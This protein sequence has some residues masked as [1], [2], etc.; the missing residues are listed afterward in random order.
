MKYCFYCGTVHEEW[1]RVTKS[2][3]YVTKRAPVHPGAPQGVEADAHVR[4]P[5]PLVR[6]RATLEVHD[7]DGDDRA[8]EVGVLHGGVL[9]AVA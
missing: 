7:D 8:I 6:Q 9:P 4:E 5:V 3:H 2:E 1:W